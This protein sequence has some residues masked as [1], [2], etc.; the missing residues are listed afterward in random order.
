[1]IPKLLFDPNGVT[2]F[3]EASNSKKCKI[4]CLKRLLNNIVIATQRY[5]CLQKISSFFSITETK[6]DVSNKAE[7]FQC[8]IAI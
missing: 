8:L 1:M 3:S 7:L 5:I 2:K 6:I 4:V